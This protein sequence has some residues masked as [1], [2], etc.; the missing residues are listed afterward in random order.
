M[1]D[2]A[3]ARGSLW[4]EGVMTGLVLMGLARL[5]PRRGWERCWL[6]RR[7]SLSVRWLLGLAWHP[8]P[9][10]AQPDPPPAQVIAASRAPGSPSR[11][12]SLP[13]AQATG[14]EASWDYLRVTPNEAV[15]PLL[16]QGWVRVMQPVRWSA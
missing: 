12:V 6:G 3:S 11:V 1:W 9:E 14:V 7:G 4:G 10:M 15:L 13:P 16:G 5:S 8:A 2:E